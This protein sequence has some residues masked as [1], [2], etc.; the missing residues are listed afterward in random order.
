MMKP[1]LAVAVAVFVVVLGIAAP[2]AAHDH[3][4][5]HLSGVQE[6][7][8]VFSDGHGFALVTLN[9]A[10]DEL[11][12]SLVYFETGSPVTQAHIHFGTPGVNGGIVAF[13]CSNLGGAPPGVPA[14]PNGPGI[15][16]VSGLITAA[17]V[18]SGAAAQ[19]IG[20]GN[21]AG[22]VEALEAKASYVNVHTEAFPAGEIR[23]PLGH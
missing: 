10:G 2:V 19:G 16:S 21:F 13:L 12:Y 14:C 15:N 11:S 8:P 17:D 20:T 18:G 6:V 7:P 5:T 22:L 23:G 4:G 1:F 3:F 9:D